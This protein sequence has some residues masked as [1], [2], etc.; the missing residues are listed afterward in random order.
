MSRRP[1]SRMEL[2]QGGP[3]RTSE[4]LLQAASWELPDKGKPARKQ[5]SVKNPRG[6]GGPMIAFLRKLGWL[7]QRR[8]KEKQLAAELQFHLDEEMEERQ[9]AGMSAPEAR[10]AARRE[11]G[12]VALAQ[13]DTRATWSWKL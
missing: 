3:K 8:T 7:L 4:D 6:P 12:N 13:E 1:P 2:P 10:G 11:L 5:L 9:A